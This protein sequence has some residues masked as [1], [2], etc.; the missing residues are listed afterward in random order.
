MYFV[1]LAASGQSVD[2]EVLTGI[3]KIVQCALLTES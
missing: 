1:A 3:G 2:C